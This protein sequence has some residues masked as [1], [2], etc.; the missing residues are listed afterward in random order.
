MNFREIVIR[1]KCERMARVPPQGLVSLKI[2]ESR[3]RATCL[4]YFDPIYTISICL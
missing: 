2:G 4:P 3:L 1:K